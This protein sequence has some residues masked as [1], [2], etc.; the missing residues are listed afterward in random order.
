[1]T[2]EERIHLILYGDIHEAPLKILGD[3]C[4]DPIP[5]D[6]EQVTRLSIAAT[7]EKE[8][9][10][11][12]TWED[13]TRFYIDMKPGDKVYLGGDMWVKPTQKRGEDALVSFNT[14]EIKHY[15]FVITR[16][17]LRYVQGEE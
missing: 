11:D 13:V 15:S 4:P 12:T 10:G 9:K 6:E 3:L 16:E 1:M 17:N 8:E 7:L 5:F 2:H 14:G